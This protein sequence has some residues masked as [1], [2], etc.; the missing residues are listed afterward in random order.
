MNATVAAPVANPVLEGVVAGLRADLGLDVRAHVGRM[1]ALVTTPQWASTDILVAIR[2]PCGPDAM[3]AAPS[4]RAIVSPLIG[5]DG[6]DLQAATDRDILVANNPVTE[7]TESMAEAAIMLMLATL[8][9]LQGS[10][11]HMANWTAGPRP[12]ARAR[13]LRGKTVS[14]L[15]FGG[16]AR[17]VVARLNGWGVE[18]LVHTRTPPAVPPQGLR[19]VSL[20]EAL[21]RG[22]VL[23]VLMDLN[24]GN[25]HL[26]DAAR[27]G[28]M[29]PGAILI[30]IARGALVD[31]AALGAQ[32]D[33]L[34]AVALDVF[35]EEPLPPDSPLRGL[36]GAVLT[37]HCVGHTRESL[38]AVTP[39]VLAIVREVLAGTIPASVRNPEV[40]PRW[41]IRWFGN[42]RTDRLPE[43]WPEGTGSM[44][45]PG[46]PRP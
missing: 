44:I 13:M 33:R 30:N 1:E 46:G 6:I 17:N 14:I 15:G 31:E 22:D 20:D 28:R 2:A 21:T 41:R 18:I 26:I 10:Q 8:Y 19:F 35:E 16:I 3:A 45:S 34:A 43:M 32:G 7:N 39:N 24:A 23:L 27:L 9:D 12:A 5:I 29:K 40:G 42:R 36:P 38:A 4:L 11:Q 25:H 37:P